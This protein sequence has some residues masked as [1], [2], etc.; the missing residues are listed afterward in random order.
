MTFNEWLS[1]LAIAILGAVSPGPSLAVVVRNTLAGSAVSG[2]LTAWSH[3]LGIGVYAVLTVLGLA[4]VLQKNPLVFEV[5]T[6]AGAI[7]LIYLG[8][9]ALRSR[10]SIAA[11]VDAGQVVGYAQ[12]LR[13]G[14]MI[15]LLNPKIGL[16]FLAL[17]SQFIHPGV[18]V[19]GKLLTIFTPIIVDGSWYTLV[20]LLLSRPNI[21]EI[22]RAKSVWID[23]IT[24]VVLILI[25]LRLVF[26]FL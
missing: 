10:G 25:A 9:K 24:G 18:G 6:Y 4:I 22:L 12:P 23:R 8:V 20:A 3:A 21:L 15:S 16:F 26:N 2:V 14:I 13:Q 5:I 19:S 7:Y 1:L 17:F 11:Q